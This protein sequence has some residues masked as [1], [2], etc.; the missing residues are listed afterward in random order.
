MVQGHS[1]DGEE[2]QT[3]RIGIRS[4]AEKCPNFS[5]FFGLPYP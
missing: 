4:D 5:G 2:S 1:A 3:G